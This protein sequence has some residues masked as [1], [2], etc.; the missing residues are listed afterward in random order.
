MKLNLDP[1]PGLRAAAEVQI[2]C[3][4][5]RIA[6]DNV[7][8]DAAHAAKRTEAREI[9]T[10]AVASA[11]FQAEADLRGLSAAEMAA[12]I[13]SKPN[14]AAARELH[15]QK[16]MARIATITTPAYLAALLANVN[17]AL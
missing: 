9:A 15:R 8:R 5:N 16:V 2:N 6:A 14:A 12:L 10:G 17:L 4:F 11:E 13:L 1:M 7:H 3:Y